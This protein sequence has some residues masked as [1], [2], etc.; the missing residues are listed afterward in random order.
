MSQQTYSGVGTNGFTD[1]PTDSALSALGLI[2][3]FTVPE[4]GTTIPYDTTKTTPSTFDIKA[5]NIQAVAD[6]A[7]ANNITH[8]AWNFE[9]SPWVN[10]SI[11]DPDFGLSTSTERYVNASLNLGQSVYNYFKAYCSSIGASINMGFYSWPYMN[12]YFPIIDYYNGLPSPSGAATTNYRNF[13][14]RLA[15]CNYR[16]SGPNL[17]STSYTKWTNLWSA[18]PGQDYDA[19]GGDYYTWSPMSNW[20]DFFSHSV[21]PAYDDVVHL[22]DHCTNIIGAITEIRNRVAGTKPIYPYTETQLRNQWYGKTMSGKMFQRQI[23]ALKSVADGLILWTGFGASYNNM[24]RFYAPAGTGGESTSGGITSVARIKNIADWASIKGAFKIKLENVATIPDILVDFTASHPSGA[25]SNYID[26]AQRIQ[27][28]VNTTLA[29]L[30]I[31]GSDYP[32]NIGDIVVTYTRYNTTNGRQDTV[33]SSDA[34]AALWNGLATGFGSPQNLRVNY[35]LISSYLGEKYA[36][37]T[38]KNPQGFRSN[39][40]N[41]YNRT[42]YT[43]TCT[44]SSPSSVPGGYTDLSGTDWLGSIRVTRYGQFGDATPSGWNGGW[45]VGND[46]YNILLREAAGRQYVPILNNSS[47]NYVI[48]V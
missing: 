31:G 3:C 19:G 47:G 5:S 28:A 36:D 14:S 35:F 39:F 2:R 9:A 43:S 20:N 7:V 25:V 16:Y 17:D 44:I 10:H 8:L 29:G 22:E 26:V 42:T 38:K 30:T 32:L 12:L 34:D 48:G 15:R 41:V 23:D 4:G 33:L 46:W 18:T 13:M 27:D 45:V 24:L 1:G 21:Y 11:L 37:G 40:D 6:L